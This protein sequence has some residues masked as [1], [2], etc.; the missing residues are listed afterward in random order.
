[1]FDLTQLTHF[2]VKVLMVEMAVFSCTNLLTPT[3][4]I[5][6]QKAFFFFHLDFFLFFSQVVNK[7][8]KCDKYKKKVT[9]VL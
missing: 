4:G 8:E 9:I 5:A 1:M 2:Q 7:Y 3:E 6:I